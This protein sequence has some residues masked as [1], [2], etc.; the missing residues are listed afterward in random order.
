MSKE[1][2]QQDIPNHHAQDVKGTLNYAVSKLPGS[3]NTTF[4]VEV[5]PY[6]Q[7][8]INFTINEKGRPKCVIYKGPPSDTSLLDEP[9]QDE[10]RTALGYKLYKEF[11][12]EKFDLK[13]SNGSNKKSFSFQG[14]QYQLL[15]K[16]DWTRLFD[17]VTDNL[18][19]YQRDYHGLLCFKD[20]NTQ[21]SA[22]DN[23]LIL[24]VGDFLSILFARAIDP[25]TKPFYWLPSKQ[26][27][28]SSLL[29]LTSSM[30][31]IEWNE[32]T[33]FFVAC[34]AD[35]LWCCYAYWQHFSYLPT[36]ISPSPSMK[37]S[38]KIMSDTDVQQ[39][40]LGRYNQLLRYGESHSYVGCVLYDAL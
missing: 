21:N 39:H 12:R 37:H 33:K 10:A 29:S 7:R 30:E 3:L 14:Q 5:H 19:T 22:T 9:S 8:S 13:N 36:R 1:L 40:N 4:F 11:I 15:T 27:A 2:K 17:Q 34:N 18:N 28:N 20:G 6:P 23:K 25:T 31:E 26:I 38:F 16:C 35:F 24:Q 32:R